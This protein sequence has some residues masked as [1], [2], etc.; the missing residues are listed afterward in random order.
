LAAPAPDTTRLILFRAGAGPLKALPLSL[1]SRIESVPS[2][3]LTQSDGTL[4][5]M[6]QGRLMPV[7]PASPDAVS[8]GSL[9][10]VLV[11]S[12]GGESMGLLVDEIVDVIEEPL[13]IQIAGGADD[14]VG[15][16]EIRGEAVDV[17]DIMHFIRQARPNAQ[18]RGVARRF[19]ILLVDDKLFFRDMLA[20][21]LTSGGYEVTVCA[22]AADALA[23]LQRG[24][25]FDAIVTDT[26]MPEMDGYRFAEAAHEQ[27]RCGHVPIIAL[28]AHPTAPV[29]AAARACGI[30]AVAGKF[31]RRALLQAVRASLSSEDLA[32]T[33]L[34]QRFLTEKA[35]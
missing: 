26:D 4:I 22:S 29:L 5:T 24:I 11:I 32:N 14:I 35:A 33:E 7:L 8:T 2:D 9:H 20:P 16:A 23:L 17:L 10:P 25:A 1:V 28:A 19:K 30:S 3:R 21:V 31:D 18:L 13:E 27:P 6:H 15:T 34:E 12:I